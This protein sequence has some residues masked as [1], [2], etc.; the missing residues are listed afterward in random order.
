M[1][2]DA[3]GLVA[4]AQRLVSAVAALGGDSGVPHP[5]LA[6]DPASVGA[7]QRSAR[8]APPSLPA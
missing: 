3:P 7:A 4:A 5:P 8:L 1:M 6:A 2:V